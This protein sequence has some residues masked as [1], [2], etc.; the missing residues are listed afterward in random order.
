MPLLTCALHISGA[1]SLKG[2]YG[3]LHRLR[4]SYPAFRAADQ[5]LRMVVAQN[6]YGL[7]FPRS[8]RQLLL[9]VYHAACAA[10]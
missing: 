2:G 7:S 1:I 8:S 10:S 9:V 6:E 5:E 3:E 4:P